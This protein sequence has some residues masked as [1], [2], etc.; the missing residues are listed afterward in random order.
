MIVKNAM[1]DIVSNAVIEILKDDDAK[2][3]KCS[4]YVEDIVCYVL[5]RIKPKYITSG[6]G[7][8]HLELEKSDNIQQ[9][10]DI[11]SLIKEAKDIIA[12]RRKQRDYIFEENDFFY[13]ENVISTNESYLNFPYF[14]G[15]VIMSSREALKKDVK[16]TLYVKD[17]G[18]YIPAEMI[19][20]N[21]QN[22]FI[23]SYYTYGYYTFW[24]NPMPIPPEDVK[25]EHEIYF[26]LRFE[27]EPYDP[28]E[29]FVEV[30]V[31]PEKAKYLSVRSGFSIRIED[32]VIDLYQ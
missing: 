19:N 23:T 25:H 24:V 9:L 27:C 8:L 32:T 20:H 6:R 1:E 31:S 29:K 7:V 28:Q 10:A 2:L 22:P 16:V 15:R 11:Y 30:N 17:K 4:A 14:T 3:L 12:K 13:K 26:K 21:W 5:N 18:K